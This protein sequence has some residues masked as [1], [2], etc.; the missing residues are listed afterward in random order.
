MVNPYTQTG[1]KASQI[2]AVPEVYL[3]HRALS[4]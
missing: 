4:G 1:R 3:T 2:G